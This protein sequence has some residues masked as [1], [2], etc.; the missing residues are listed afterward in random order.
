MSN[1][2]YELNKDSWEPMK[3]EYGKDS[4]LYMIE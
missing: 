3:P 2:L 1:K 4:V